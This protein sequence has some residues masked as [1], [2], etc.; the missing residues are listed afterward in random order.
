MVD[1][2]FVARSACA[3]N[4]G[5]HGGYRF[6]GPCP[7]NRAAHGARVKTCQPKPGVV[8]ARTCAAKQNKGDR[9]RQPADCHFLLGPNLVTCL[10]LRSFACFVSFVVDPFG[11]F[12]RRG[13]ERHCLV[14][15]SRATD[16]R[17]RHTLPAFPIFPGTWQRLPRTRDSLPRTHEIL[18]LRSTSA[19]NS[20]LK[21]TG[22]QIGAANRLVIGPVLFP[23][24]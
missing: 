21:H 22:L 9:G 5:K 10:D 18:A 19:N 23:D 7:A 15:A 11:S 3:D 4:V 8:F 17:L 6:V 1:V 12:A 20:C 14:E 16:R 24:R 13:G 2:S